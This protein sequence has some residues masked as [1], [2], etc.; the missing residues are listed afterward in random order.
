MPVSARQYQFSASFKTAAKYPLHDV[1][2]LT[3]ERKQNTAVVCWRPMFLHPLWPP[4]S[5]C[6]VMISPCILLC[7]CLS[8]TWHMSLWATYWKIWGGQ[9]LKLCKC[10]CHSSIGVWLGLVPKMVPNHIVSHPNLITISLKMVI[11]TWFFPGA[12]KMQFCDLKISAWQLNGSCYE[13]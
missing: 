13:Q 4:P 1:T 6:S 10:F 7:S 3:A 5:S 11:N 9:S 2:M 8:I 12:K